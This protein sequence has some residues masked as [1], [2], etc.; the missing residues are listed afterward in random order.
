MR[1]HSRARPGTVLRSRARKER[2]LRAFARFMLRVRETSARRARAYKGE[3]RET[4]RKISDTTLEIA[5]EVK[6]WRAP[7]ISAN[8]SRADGLSSWM[9]CSFA[10]VH[11][12]VSV[13]GGSRYL[14]VTALSCCLRVVEREL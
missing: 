3:E 11:V 12:C 1:E 14:T 13:M 10:S 2:S 6:K 9:V 5:R 8:S 7:S 4:E